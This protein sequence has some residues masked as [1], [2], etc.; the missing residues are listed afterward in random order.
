[1]SSHPPDLLSDDE[2]D[3]DS[4]SEDSLS[5]SDSGDDNDW[6]VGLRDVVGCRPSSKDYDKNGLFKRTSD[7]YTNSDE[8][9]REVLSV[10]ET[11][12][13]V[14]DYPSNGHVSKKD[15]NKESIAAHTH[16][17]V[18]PTSQLAG[19]R[20]RKP[21]VL[22]VPAYNQ[23]D[24][25]IQRKN[26]RTFYQ[27]LLENYTDYALEDVSKKC[28]EFTFKKRSEVEVAVNVF[29]DKAVTDVAHAKPIASLCT[30]MELHKIHDIHLFRE[31]MLA[32]CQKKFLQIRGAV[33]VIEEVSCR[34]FTDCEDLTFELQ[35]EANLDHWIKWTDVEEKMRCHMVFLGELY[36]FGELSIKVVLGRVLKMFETKSSRHLDYLSITGLYELLRVAGPKLDIELQ[37]AGELVK[38]QYQ[39]S[40]ENLRELYSDKTYP[41]HVRDKLWSIVR[42]KEN[43]WKEHPETADK[44]AAQFKPKLT[45]SSTS[46]SVATQ[47]SEPGKVS[48]SGQTKGAVQSKTSSGVQGASVDV[49]SRTATLVEDPASKL[50]TQ[51]KDTPPP[52]VTT[53]PQPLIVKPTNQPKTTSN[54]KIHNQIRDNLSKAWRNVTDGEYSQAVSCY[55]ECLVLFKVLSSPHPHMEETLICLYVLVTQY[56]TKDNKTDRESLYGKI[57]SI[58]HKTFPFVDYI[59]LQQFSKSC[60]DFKVVLTHFERLNKAV[61]ESWNQV[62]YPL[63]QRLLEESAPDKMRDWLKSFVSSQ[64]LAYKDTFHKCVHVACKKPGN[65]I[66]EYEDFESSDTYEV[67]ECSEKCKQYYHHHCFKSL[68]KWNI[69]GQ[70]L[71]PDCSG[72]I[73]RLYERRIVKRESKTPNEPKKGKERTAVHPP[74]SP[75]TKK[76]G[77][78]RQDSGTREKRDSASEVV[79]PPPSPSPPTPVPLTPSPEPEFT[80]DD[81]IDMFGTML[82]YLEEYPATHL[83]TVVMRMNSIYS[84]VRVEMFNEFLDIGVQSVTISNKGELNLKPGTDKEREARRENDVSLLIEHYKNSP[85]SSLKQK[86]DQNNNEKPEIA[87]PKS[88][89]R[90]K[91][92]SCEKQYKR[93]AKNSGSKVDTK[94]TGSEQ[95]C[96]RV[97]TP[98]LITKQRTTSGSLN[99]GAAVFSPPVSKLPPSFNTT[100]PGQLHNLL[101]PEFRPRPP[102]QQHV[103]QIPL[104]HL[105]PAAPLAHFPPQSRQPNTIHDVLL[106]RATAQLNDTVTIGAPIRPTPEQVSYKERKELLERI[107]ELEDLLK[108]TENKYEKE[109]SHMKTQLVEQLDE[110][111][112]LKSKAKQYK[113][114]AKQAQDIIEEHNKLQDRH[115]KILKQMEDERRNWLSERTGKSV[116]SK[117][118]IV[119]MKIE[120]EEANKRNRELET[121]CKE[122][123]KENEELSEKLLKIESDLF[124]RDQSVMNL[125]S[126]VLEL[127]QKYKGT[128]QQHVLERYNTA[129]LRLRIAYANCEAQ[130]RERAKLENPEFYYLSLW[131]QCQTT[132]KN[133]IDDNTHIYQEYVSSLHN[134][135]DLEVRFEQEPPCPAVEVDVPPL[136]LQ[137]F[138]DIL[139]GRPAP[140]LPAPPSSTQQMDSELNVLADLMRDTA[141]RDSTIPSFMTSQETS[142]LPLFPPNSSQLVAS[143][144][145]N[146]ASPNS[147]FQFSDLDIPVAKPSTRPPS[148]GSSNTSRPPSSMPL[149]LADI[150]SRQPAPHF[151]IADNGAPVVS[152]TRQPAFINDNIPSSAIPSSAIPSSAIPSSAIPSSAIPSSVI[153]SSA[154]PSSAIPSSSTT[155]IPGANRSSPVSA[156]AQPTEPARSAV[157]GR[158]R[159]RNQRSGQSTVPTAVGRAESPAGTT[160]PP[161]GANQPP[162]GVTSPQNI[163]HIPPPRAGGPGARAGAPRAAALKNRIKEKFPF[164]SEKEINRYLK[165]VKEDTDAQ[166]IKVTPTIAL[167]RVSELVET[168][169]P[170]APPDPTVPVVPERTCVI[171]H[172]ALNLMAVTQLG[173]GHDFHKNCVDQWFATQNHTCPTC[174]SHEPPVDMFPPLTR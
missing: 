147:H 30:S 18:K 173:C 39:T 67:L 9:T 154:I 135:V 22:E 93:L 53:P 133:K 118:I 95:K 47:K 97:Q 35:N 61:E 4:A 167:Q 81:I 79:P 151:L 105:P 114:E 145:A 169:Y 102:P 174:R 111:S 58:N 98:D 99:P 159:T 112:R 140:E 56:E 75:R 122:L 146:T 12:P 16:S 8:D 155:L 104:S 143:T 127:N 148:S 134:S 171:C 80:G 19:A 85:I 41:A 3:S 13:L 21:L 163:D 156:V 165:R 59:H 126:E 162:S 72:K 109:I 172:E 138:D 73:I 45:K 160:R 94:E 142:Q 166:G 7:Y 77:K 136:P 57:E 117:K 139:L 76:K 103:P 91:H 15:V 164:L 130:I 74:P 129:Q 63:S 46:S 11:D 86:I 100:F 132:I 43:N 92:P 27:T 42:L 78:K 121:K 71:T 6:P 110:H 125:K 170:T 24:P 40:V 20:C 26:I 161:A 70:C 128:Q 115:E 62:F 123:T 144:P 152:E 23:S 25:E 37:R 131:Q 168:D 31:T 124:S 34:K 141:M 88:T 48:S 84:W 108:E 14:G 137:R 101:A 55:N 149:D 113:Q 150:M 38:M 51:R 89:E 64:Q 52:S 32:V 10:T 87:K 54:D 68:G 96:E 82:I 69:D 36:N 158:G 17:D 106:S 107:S 29:Y 49:G 120:I 44:K 90:K 1:M 116:E 2:I 60:G 153:P 119:T 5:D 66:V 33:N 28:Q 83:T 65:Y 157:R 50:T